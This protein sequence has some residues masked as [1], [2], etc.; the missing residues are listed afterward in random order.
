MISGGHEAAE[1][2]GGA[3][4]AGHAADLGA[5]SVTLA[6]RAKVAPL[7]APR[8]AAMARNAT[9]PT[10]S[11]GGRRRLDRRADGHHGE[12]DGQHRDRAEPVGEPA[13]D[14]AHDHGDDARSRPSGSRR[15]P[16]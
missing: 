10:G 16:G 2:A 12:A 3:D 6:T 9:V 11:S 7:P 5:G 15:R 1:A 14:R 4:Q 8:A 13:A